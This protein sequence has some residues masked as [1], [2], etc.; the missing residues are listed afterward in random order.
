M[1]LSGQSDSTRVR[2]WHRPRRDSRGVAALDAE[3]ND[4]R[5]TIDPAHARL[6]Y[7]ERQLEH[8][9]T[10]GLANASCVRSL[11][12]EVDAAERDLRNAQ[13]VLARAMLR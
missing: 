7:A 2:G 11:E 9:T 12:A 4:Q 10:F 5:Q 1:A 3:M 6:A 13:A 8:E